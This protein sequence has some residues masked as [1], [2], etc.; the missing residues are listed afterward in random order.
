M[1]MYVCVAYIAFAKSRTAGKGG[2]C[3]CIK[4]CSCV[5]D[6]IAM[7]NRFLKE[8]ELYPM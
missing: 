4:S 7:E 5:V 8:L 6:Y 3:V 1:D 2:V